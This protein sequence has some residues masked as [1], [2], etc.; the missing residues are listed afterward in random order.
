MIRMMYL[1][2]YVLHACQRLSTYLGGG[3]HI[4]KVHLCSWK[5]HLLIAH[6]SI[7]CAYICMQLAH[8]WA[9]LLGAVA[10]TSG[11]TPSLTNFSATDMLEHD[12]QLLNLIGKN[13][14]SLLVNRWGELAL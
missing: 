4:S 10:I 5:H 8:T 2:D 12:L 7:T 13:P 1:L 6:A 9:V 14:G 11:T 3:H